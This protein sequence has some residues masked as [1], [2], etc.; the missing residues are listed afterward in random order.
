MEIPFSEQYYVEK[1]RNY[2]YLFLSVLV[3]IFL[4]IFHGILFLW[5]PW[6]LRGRRTVDTLKFRHFFTFVKYFETVTQTFNI[7]I[8]G[9]LFYFQPSLLLVGLFHIGIN[10]VFAIS[11]TRDLTYEDWYYIVSK[12]VGRLATAHVPIILILVA[13]NNIV[14]AASGLTSDKV[15]FFHKWYGRSMFITTIIHMA[16]SLKYWLGMDFKIMVE[17]PPQIFGFIAFSCLGMLNLASLKFI[18]NIAFEFFLAQHRIFNFIMLLLAYFH[19][20]GNHAAMILGVHLLVVDRVIARVM[21]IL[22][23]RKGPTKGLCDFEI[24]DES[25]VRVSIPISVKRSSKKWFWFFLPRYGNWRAGQHVYFNC[26]KIALMAYHPFTIASLPDLGKMVL[27]I[28]VQRGFTK[29]LHKKL[30]KLTEEDLESA[31]GRDIDRSGYISDSGRST[32]QLNSEDSPDVGAFTKSVE[33]FHAMLSG[34]HPPR[35]FNLK[36]GING[37]FGANYQPLTKF[38]SVVFFSA[39]SGASFTL[40]VALDLLKTIQQRDDTE[41]YLYRPQKTQITIVMVMK[42]KSNLQ[43]YDH[44]W[45]EFIPF[46]NSG[47]AH[48]ALHITQE[49]PAEIEYS[50]EKVDEKFDYS[51]E[52]TSSVHDNN[53]SSY[54][55]MV[56]GNGGFSVTHRRPDFESIISSSVSVLCS[57]SYRKAFACVACGPGSFN[58]KIKRACEKNRWLPNA[59]D[60][61]CYDES[62]E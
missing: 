56:F 8:M 21:G 16:L 5:V 52:G 59:P 13:K 51:Q 48:L 37:P 26:N 19:N 22:H 43:W 41:D 23:K 33:D 31:V 30:A 46:F 28:K 40:P 25:T 44:L 24:L 11:E 53:S 3:T 27:V 38:D 54:N 39:G 57:P 36:A 1:E 9:K 17:I 12:R 15:V 7:R 61:Y 50:Q 14:S 35:I 20:G 34:F 29:K 18:R 2:K 45:K 10:S 60:V 58:G 62:F 6:V 32:D 47:K 42:K 55:M 4:P 49:A